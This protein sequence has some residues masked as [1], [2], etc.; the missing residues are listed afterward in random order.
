MHPPSQCLS[1]LS[2]FLPAWAAQFFHPR[3]TALRCKIPRYLPSTH[4]TRLRLLIVPAW[5]DISHVSTSHLFAISFIIASSRACSHL[6]G[7][8]TK[9]CSDKHSPT[10]QEPR[11]RQHQQQTTRYHTSFPYRH[12]QSI[13]FIIRVLFC[14]HLHPLVLLPVCHQPPQPAA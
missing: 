2:F 4:T 10:K 6:A 8:T 11:S 3:M 13:R 12:P 1:L 5:S 9:C 7:F 14:R